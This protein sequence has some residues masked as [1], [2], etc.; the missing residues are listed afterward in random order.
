MVTDLV[1]KGSL[2]PTLPIVQ[3]TVFMSDLD[4]QLEVF[5][6]EICT[7]RTRYES[8]SP[9]DDESQVRDAYGS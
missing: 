7:L 9:E 2:L 8:R 1:V 6:E 4:A 5:D 3:V